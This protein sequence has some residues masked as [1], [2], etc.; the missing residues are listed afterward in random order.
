M[1]PVGAVEQHGPHLPVSVDRDLIQAV[2][3][4]AV[5]LIDPALSVLVLPTQAI[6]SNEH[7]GFPGTP[8]FSAETLIRV[9]MEIGRSV[10]RAGIRKMVL[11][12]GH[13]GNVSTMDIVA[14]DL[15]AE[16]GMLVAHCSWFQFSRSETFLDAHE[17]EHEIHGGTGE[18][19]AMLVARPDVVKMDLAKPFRSQ[20]E[21]WKADTAHIGVGGPV[22]LGW[23][24]QDLNVDGAAG[25]ASK[26]TAEIGEAL[27]ANAA[28]GFAAFL[29]DFD[30][31]CLPICRLEG[32]HEGPRDP[33]GRAPRLESRHVRR[34]NWSR[35]TCRNLRTERSAFG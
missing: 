14:R 25:D 20:G 17:Y 5:P 24:M 29:K 10:H 32:D 11:F 7:I 8:T 22:K 15:R 21:D 16:L 33:V 12:N 35:S 4:R 28:D 3:D 9:W 27:I 18:T 19:S 1:L 34:S 2:V 23:L 31:K 13:G 6:G 30:L 26:A